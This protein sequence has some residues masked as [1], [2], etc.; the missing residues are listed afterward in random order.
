MSSPSLQ[1]DDPDT[2]FAAAPWNLDDTRAA[3]AGIDVPTMLAPEER[4]FYFWAARNWA[5]DAG[6]VVDLG[7]FAGGSTARLAAG[8][9]A[10]EG[11]A[12]VHA[13]D[14]FTVDE[15]T[16][17]RV[18]YAQGVPP[19]DGSDILPL[20]QQFLAPWTDRIRFHQG[21]IQDLG[22]SGGQIE[23]L[24]IDAF[25]RASVLDAVSEL[26]YPSLIPGRSLLIQQDFLAWNQPWIVS[27]MLR[28]GEC[29]KPVAYTRGDTVVF[30]CTAAITAEHLA[31]A[32][33]AERTDTQ[34]IA[35]LREMRD[36]LE[37]WGLTP[38]FRKAVAALRQNPG[39]RIAWQMRPPRGF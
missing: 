18:L 31:R 36:R 27:Q 35:D 30:L 19:F 25:K 33:V 11:R 17:D 6:D 29:L 37:D 3:V 8:V 2:L 14:R 5:Q 34:L 28:L 12:T 39:K 32:N 9:A 26:F 4:R 1:I 38:R 10:R 22:W 23:L 15:N 16:K 13:Y 21:E 24:A 7:A 20:A